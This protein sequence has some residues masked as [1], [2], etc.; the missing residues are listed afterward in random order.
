[1]KI[2]YIASPYT[3]RPGHSVIGN[4]Q[5]AQEHALALAALHIPFFCPVIHT[6][7][8]DRLLGDADPG[9]GYWMRYTMEMLARCDAVLA[10]PGWKDSNG[11]RLEIGW[12]LAHHRPV[13]ETLHELAE[14]HEHEYALS[15]D[16]LLGEWM[17]AAYREGE[18]SRDWYRLTWLVWQEA[19]REQYAIDTMRRL[20]RRTLDMVGVSVPAIPGIDSY[21]AFES[22]ATEERQARVRAFNN[23]RFIRIVGEGEDGE[24]EK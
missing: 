8:F 14:W 10:V 2:V 20:S 23:M 24:S 7:H 9:Y 11:C 18:K 16:G 5:K 15:I 4:V 22:K 19:E 3:A 6:A 17:S 1:M 12:A 21:T 13:F